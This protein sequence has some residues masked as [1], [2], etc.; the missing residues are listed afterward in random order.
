MAKSNEPTPT[1]L[2]K[3]PDTTVM[4]DVLSPLHLMQLEVMSR[5]IEIASLQRKCRELELQKK[6]LEQ[7]VVAFECEAATRQLS[8]SNQNFEDKK[9]LRTTMIAGIKDVYGI[10]E[11]LSYNPDNGVI[12][13]T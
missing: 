3:A 4:V 12:V 1:K 2:A 7:K 9:R 8:Q 11:N 10:A 13:R 5:D 6:M